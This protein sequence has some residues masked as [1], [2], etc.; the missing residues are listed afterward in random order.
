MQRSRLTL[1]IAAIALGVASVLGAA[2]KD[3]DNP[4]QARASLDGAAVFQ[5]YCGQ[6]HAERYPTERIQSK[7]TIIATHM[8]VRGQLTGQEAVAVLRY[9]QDNARQ[10]E[11]APQAA[12]S[13]G[14]EARP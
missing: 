4:R 13:A 8:R 7:W 9:L 6:C 12:A 2:A 3:R 14:E 11:S 1:S 5:R 10:E